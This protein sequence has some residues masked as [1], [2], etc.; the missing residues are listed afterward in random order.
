MAGIKK[1]VECVLVIRWNKHKNEKIIIIK[2]VSWLSWCSVFFY[3]SYRYLMVAVLLVGFVC[4][5]LRVT[6]YIILTNL[7]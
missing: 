7:D 5:N 4:S 3:L 1:K 2:D 6:S